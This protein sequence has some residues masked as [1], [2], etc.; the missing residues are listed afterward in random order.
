MAKTNRSETQSPLLRQILDGGSGISYDLIKIGKGADPKK[1]F[2]SNK[3]M[4][5]SIIFKYPHFR[6]DLQ[7][8]FDP[9]MMQ[10][11]PSIMGTDTSE[12][13]VETGLYIPHLTTDI[14]S[15]G[16]VIYL[17]SDN[18]EELLNE[19]FGFDCNDTSDGVIK[20]L[21]ILRVLDNIP[22]LDAFLL[23]TAFELEHVDV[24]QNYIDISDQEVRNIKEVIGRRIDPII[25]KAVAS[26][27]TDETR[28]E[29]FLA[30]IWDP[31]LP[32]A[33]LFVSAFGI[34]QVDADKVF[35]GWKGVSFYEYQLRRLSTRAVA[36]LQWL[37]SEK[38]IPH[39]M[40]Y[41]AMWEST[42]MTMTEN[43][44][45]KIDAVIQDIRVILKEYEKAFDTFMNDKPSD[46]GAFLKTVNKKYWLM[47]FCVSSLASVVHANE[48]YWTVGHP[49]KLSFDQM[50]AL[51]RQMDVAVS[52]Q[53]E[54]V[55]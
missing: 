4:N 2:F 45:K 11:L 31:S 52:R 39:D 33:R 8:A 36:V 51:L 30:A 34:N 13:P 17:R 25:R 29:K 15:G 44:G 14:A 49:K 53:R 48:R 7:A 54:R 22:S 23:K 47:G 27:K 9:S 16:F 12:R 50:R 42:L 24:P 38:A 35:A 41:N 37:K 5:N 32:E 6:D 43:V 10:S 20:D 1:L 40:K 18:Y 55:G 19:H 3:A 26:R 28:T 21:K 46:F